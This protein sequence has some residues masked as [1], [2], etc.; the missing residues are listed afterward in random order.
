[1]MTSLSNGHNPN[2]PEWQREQKC[3]DLIAEALA[4]DQ[5][6]K[7]IRRQA[8]NEGSW[9]AVYQEATVMRHKLQ[10]IIGELQEHWPALY[11]AARGK[12]E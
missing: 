9:S 1:M 8:W 2:S 7:V 10:R 6:A 12:G 3:L 5:H 11:A 4:L